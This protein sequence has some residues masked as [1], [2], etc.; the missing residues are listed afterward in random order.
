MWSRALWWSYWVVAVTLIIALTWKLLTSG[1][2]LLV[3]VGVAY[4]IAIGAIGAGVA[5]GF[6]VWKFWSEI[7]HAAERAGKPASDPPAIGAKLEDAP[8]PERIH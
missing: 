2:F 7:Q 6:A 8:P 5:V 3:A 4:A 1:D